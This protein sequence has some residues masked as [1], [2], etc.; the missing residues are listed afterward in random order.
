MNGIGVSFI[1]LMVRKPRRS[2]MPKWSGWSRMQP[3]R[4]MYL[5]ILSSIGCS[6]DQTS[7][8][9]SLLGYVVAAIL[10]LLSSTAGAADLATAVRDSAGNLKVILWD[11]TPGGGLIRRGDSGSLAGAISLVSAVALPHMVL[12]R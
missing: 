10:L 7:K 1:L 11:V 3:L 9:S 12:H 4:A 6:K 5:G 8:R 2:A